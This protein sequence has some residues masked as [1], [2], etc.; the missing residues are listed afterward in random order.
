MIKFTFRKID[1]CGVFERPADDGKKNS[2]DTFNIAQFLSIEKLTQLANT[3]GVPWFF[4]SSVRLPLN[5]DK[6]WLK[7]FF[8]VRRI[9]NSLAY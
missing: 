4:L 1:L 8:Q 2:Q 9:V 3:K 7:A 6:H 5:E